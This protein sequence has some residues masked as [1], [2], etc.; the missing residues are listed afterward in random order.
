MFVDELNLIGINSQK[1]RDG[2][3][4]AR[5]QAAGHVFAAGLALRAVADGAFKLFEF[6]RS[7]RHKSPRN[8][9]TAAA[10]AM[11]VSQN[12]IRGSSRRIISASPTGLRA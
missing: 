12:S 5:C 1:V 8:A 11:T 3:H 7:H 6:G 2:V 4:V 9:M 10:K